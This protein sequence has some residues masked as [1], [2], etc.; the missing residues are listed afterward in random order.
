MVTLSSHGGSPSSNDG[1]LP[2]IGLNL[3]ICCQNVVKIP[4][5]HWS[6]TTWSPSTSNIMSWDRW[7]VSMPSKA[8]IQVNEGRGRLSNT[9]QS[10]SKGNDFLVHGTIL[11]CTCPSGKVLK[12]N[13]YA[14]HGLTSH[15]DRS[16]KITS[17]NQINQTCASNP[18]LPGQMLKHIMQFN[19]PGLKRVS[20]CPI[21][22]ILLK[23]G[24]FPRWRPI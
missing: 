14:L 18:P 23:F 12:N 8:I 4:F 17:N 6:M 24:M 2:L 20:G 5:F 1:M 13:K 9:Y 7:M 10:A 21:G 16:M 19:K 15:K 3:T 22:P 11:Q